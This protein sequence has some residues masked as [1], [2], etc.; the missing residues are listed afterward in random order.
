MKASKIFM[1]IFSGIIGAIIFFILS[2][3]A[4][5]VAKIVFLLSNKQM[6]ISLYTIGAVCLAFVIVGFIYGAESYIKK[7]SLKDAFRLKWR[8]FFLNV[9]LTALAFILMHFVLKQ[10]Y[11]L[12]MRFIPSVGLITGLFILFYPFSCVVFSFKKR[13]K[14]H[15]IRNIFFSILLN[16]VF[17]LAAL[18]LFIIAAYGALYVPCSVTIMGVDKNP[19]TIP[20]NTLSL[21]ISPGQKIVSIDGHKIVKLDD[22]RSYLNSIGTT[23]QVLLETEKNYYYVNTYR[24]QGTGKRY[25]G[26]LLR[27]DYCYRTYP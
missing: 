22:V 12:V 6:I 14:K 21:D 13:M 5:S 2:M 3:I 15:K 19:G 7:N 26:L 23:K 4:F 9:L 25:L 11:G 8:G 18:W 10:N 27:Q 1:A 20:I 16:P 17:I 24:D